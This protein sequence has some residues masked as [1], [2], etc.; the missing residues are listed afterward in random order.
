ML[1]T[2]PAFKDGFCAPFWAQ[3]LC[4]YAGATFKDVHV[5]AT[6]KGLSTF[7]DGSVG[8]PQRILML[9]IPEGFQ[10]EGNPITVCQGL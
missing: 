9:K 5:G 10:T 1:H 7:K 3:I 4:A 6:F 2:G 8:I